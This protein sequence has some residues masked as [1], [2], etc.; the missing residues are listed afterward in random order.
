MT[1]KRA[2]RRSLFD[3]PGSHFAD[4]LLG[5]SPLPLEHHRLFCNM[6][7]LSEFEVWSRALKQVLPEAEKHMDVRPITTKLDS[8]NLLNYYEYEDVDSTKNR[9]EKTRRVFHY[10]AS[11]D[12]M[13]IKKFV[14]ILETSSGFERWAREIKE[15]A[16]IPVTE[17]VGESR[18]PREL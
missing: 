1:S 16:G 17:V 8:N 3:T 5:Q 4:L 13:Y 12:T 6:S 11:K 14:Y 7:A 9:I 18:L 15:A 2:E 10:M